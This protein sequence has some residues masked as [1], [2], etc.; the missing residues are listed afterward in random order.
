MSVILKLPNPTTLSAD[1]SRRFL[2]K[3]CLSRKRGGPRRKWPLHSIRA[4]KL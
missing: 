2:C 4:L 1:A 3:H